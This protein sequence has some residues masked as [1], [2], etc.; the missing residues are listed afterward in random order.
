[1]RVV[2][3]E[4]ERLLVGGF[5][6]EAERRETNEERIRRASSA[7]AESD[8]ERLTLRAGKTRGE[9]EDWEAENLQ[10]RVVEVCLSLDA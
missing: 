7:D 5:P 6:H 10:C 4:H 3:D 1:M 8:V 9:L 2:D